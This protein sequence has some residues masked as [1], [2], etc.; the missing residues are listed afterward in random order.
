MRPLRLE[1]SGFTSFREPVEIDFTDADLFVLTGPMGAGKSSIIDALSFA[2]YGSVARLQNQA[3][4]APIISQGLSEARVR[5]DF[6]LDEQQYSAV[7]VVRR[8]RTG[9]AS[10]AEA[11]LLCG[12]EVVEGAADQVTDRITRL[13]GLNF[14]QFNRCV[15]L[16]Q[17]E[18]ASLLHARA[19][20]RQELL[21]QLLDIGLYRRVGAAA[22]RQ[23]EII[24]ARSEPLKQRLERDLLGA[25][26]QAYDEVEAR[27]VTLAELEKK[28]AAEQED[29]DSLLKQAAEHDEAARA[30]TEV[31][32]TL[33]ALAV[34]EGLE[35]LAA[36]ITQARAVAAEASAGLQRAAAAVTQAHE[37]R[38]TLPELAAIKAV[39]DRYA[40]R[41]TRLKAVASSEQL[42][43][44]AAAA[45]KTAD[46]ALEAATKTRASREAAVRKLERAHSAYHAAAGLNVG[47]PCPVCGGTIETPPAI[48]EPAGLAQ[49]E[50][51][52]VAAVRELKAA[53]ETRR[54][55]GDSHGRMQAGLEA[56]R[57]ALSQLDTQLKDAPALAEARK[58]TAAIEAA[59]AAVGTAQ[60]AHDAAQKRSR[61]A[62]A[63]LEDL[64]ETEGNAWFVFNTRRDEVASLGAPPAGPDIAAS[65]SALASWA[66]EEASR[67]SEVAQTSLTKRDELRTQAATL[68]AEMLAACEG[69][70]ITVNGSTPR[71]AALAAR[72][73]TEQELTQLDNKIAE[74]D[75]VEREL[76][77]LQDTSRVAGVLGYH[78]NATRF[79][80][81][82]LEEAL[83]NLVEGATL[84]L[85]ELSDGQYSLALNKNKTDFIV[86]DHLNLDEERSVRT[87]SGGETFL[88]S[89]ALALAL[90]DNI[91]TLATNGGARLDALFLDEGF[92]SLDASTLETVASAIEEMGARG[93]MVGI[94]THV[95]ELAERIPVK[96]HVT[97]HGRTSR[98]ERAEAG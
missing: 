7:R 18:F 90:G 64:K 24:G 5:L 93:R 4:V 77:G 37:A 27:L 47:D 55:V 43:K 16:P 14:D 73:R 60:A 62:D 89:L 58:L 30:V 10:T 6:L 98:V 48:A 33:E 57:L 3:M 32:G 44:Q 96:F 79:E 42:V 1:L 45:L 35:D 9:G 80:R 53:E 20:E 68:R 23:V 56:A 85:N 97:K 75:T 94:I 38:A 29:L 76:T 95:P 72:V 67:R 31:T 83:T 41:E 17:G 21:V 59:Q 22:R 40:E 65:W 11:R 71:D 87:L 92:G 88:A 34:P 26:H 82:Y 81:W 74:R 2:L 25:T 39:I 61:A 46:A 8:T 50:A 51:A 36:Q 54:K 49:A 66:Q 13:I 70:G 78:L 86:I 63:A 91:A 19:A 28:L 52:L 15:V 69:A 84:R 12:D